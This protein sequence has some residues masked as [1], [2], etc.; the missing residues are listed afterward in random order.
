MLKVI[1]RAFSFFK[2]PV[3]AWIAFDSAGFSLQ[4][5]SKEAEQFSWQDVLEIVAFKHDQITTDLICLKITGRDGQSLVL[6]EE[7][8]GFL[9]FEA[10]MNSI[11]NLKEWRSKVVLPPFAANRTVIYQ[12]S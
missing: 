8:D 6:H 10:K 5:K 9:E 4:D 12:V 3:P 1:Q 11:F 2:R 7:M